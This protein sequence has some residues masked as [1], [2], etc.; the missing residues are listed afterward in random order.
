MQKSKEAAYNASLLYKGE[1]A[2]GI[3]V[4]TDLCSQPE[5]VKS[6]LVLHQS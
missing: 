1:Q 6:F 4:R 2:E 5:P 3:D